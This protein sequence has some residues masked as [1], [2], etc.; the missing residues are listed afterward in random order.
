M[1]HVFRNT[2]EELE[3]GVKILNDTLANV[4]LLDSKLNFG[5]RRPKIFRYHLEAM[6]DHMN[7]ELSIM[8]M[9]K[10]GYTIVNKD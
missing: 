3:E 6:K 4:N 8:E 5:H 9:K 1:E 10:Q 7:R 2:K